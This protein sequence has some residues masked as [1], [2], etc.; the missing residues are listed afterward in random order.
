[1]ELKKVN[2]I[3]NDCYKLYKS[4]YSTELNDNDLH[5]FLKATDLIR[6]KYNCKM[7]DDVLISV[8][9]EIDRIEK[10]IHCR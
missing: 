8:I 2:E 7:A 4:F 6:K 3:F 5:D 9:D 10:E 1:M